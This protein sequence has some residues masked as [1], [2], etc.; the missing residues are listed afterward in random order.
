V[1]YGLNTPEQPNISSTRW[2]TV[3]DHKRK[4]YFFESA[5]TPNTFWVDLKAIDFATE[6]GKV[7]KLDL[8]ENQDHT[9]SGNATNEFREAQP[10]RFLG[11]LKQ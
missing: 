2:R 10:F 11:P 3:F 7:K 4:L 9:Y 5:L 6:T 1:R 8:G